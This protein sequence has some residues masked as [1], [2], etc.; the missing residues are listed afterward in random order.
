MTRKFI[1]KKEYPNSCSLGTIFT[2]ELK[3]SYYAQDNSSKHGAVLKRYSSNWK[4]D[5][6]TKN[7]EYYEEVI[8]KDYEILSFYQP[9]H[10]GLNIYNLLAGCKGMFYELEGNTTGNLVAEELLLKLN[11]S[12][13]SVKRLSDGEVF[14][15]GDKI[16]GPSG[17]NEEIVKIDLDWIYYRS[18]SKKKLIY[19]YKLKDIKKA[20]TP[21]FTT[22]PLIAVKL[23][24]SEI[25]KLKNL[26]M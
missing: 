16:D 4:T 22:E 14:T 19:T 6:F 21:I 26:L 3:D 20:K 13:H 25:N 8:E 15:V 23:T 24:Q 5:Y 7:P 2:E 9:D 1:L 18:N 11:Y 17:R 10:K 12:I